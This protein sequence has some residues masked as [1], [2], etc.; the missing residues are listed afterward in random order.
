L[1][2]DP[3]IAFLHVHNALSLL[4]GYLLAGW[5]PQLEDDLAANQQELEDARDIWLSD[6]LIALGVYME[7]I[8]STGADDGLFYSYT[9]V[10]YLRSFADKTRE[11]SL[12]T[13]RL[14]VGLTHS[15]KVWC[16]KLTKNEFCFG[17][18]LRAILRGHSTRLGKVKDEPET[19]GKAK[20]EELGTVTNGNGRSHGKQNGKRSVKVEETKKKN[21]DEE[22]EADDVVRQADGA[23]E[24]L[25]TLC[26]ALGL[27]TNLIQVDDEVKNTLR[28]TCA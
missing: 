2:N 21:S 6:G 15:D 19:N 27:L 5:S 1:Y 25:D 14:L 3:H 10:R 18:I 22:S 20:R 4:D 11:C 9:M 7:A 23:E 17:F 16:A 8:V 12:V 26:L 13:L 24:A 28:E